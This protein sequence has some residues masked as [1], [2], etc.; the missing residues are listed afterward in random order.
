MLHKVHNLL[1]TKL[2]RICWHNENKEDSPAPGT[3]WQSPYS[4]ETIQK[5]KGPTAAEQ[6]RATGAVRSNGKRQMC[7][8]T[9]ALYFREASHLYQ[10]AKNTT[11]P[12]VRRLN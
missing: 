10:I 1:Y 6:P 12:F 2:A 7:F 9:L 11:E 5:Q 8:G 4:F 3:M